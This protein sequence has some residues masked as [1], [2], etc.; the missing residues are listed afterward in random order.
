[1]KKLSIVLAA[2]LLTSASFGADMSKA[3]IQK[4][5][6]KTAQESISLKKEASQLEEKI[7]Q[8]CAK[9]RQL[10][11]VVNNLDEAQRAEFLSELK[12]Q[13]RQ[14]LAKLKRDD[15]YNDRVC[16]NFGGFVGPKAKPAKF[17]HQRQKRMP[18]CPNMD[19]QAMK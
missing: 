8:I 1:M 12:Y 18:Q 2:S 15:I 16:G 6:S 9:E 5:A 19:C 4:L 11:A 13:N 17:D 10:K 3:E 14:G 7:A